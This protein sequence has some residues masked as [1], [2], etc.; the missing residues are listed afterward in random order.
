MHLRSF[1]MLLRFEKVEFI[2]VYV[3]RVKCISEYKCVWRTDVLNH[4]DAIL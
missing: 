1:Q 2:P 3:Y 4:Y